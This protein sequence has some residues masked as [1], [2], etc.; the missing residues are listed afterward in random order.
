MFYAKVFYASFVY[1]CLFHLLVQKLFLPHSNFFEHVQYFLNRVKFFDH[2]QMQD[3]TLYIY[4]F[5]HCQKYL[6]TFKKYWTQS[7]IFEHGQKIIELADGL[8]TR[9]EFPQPVL[10]YYFTQMVHTVEFSFIL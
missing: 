6:D 9:V 8:D 2:G 3:F 1:P 4:K 10:P 7:K 5:E